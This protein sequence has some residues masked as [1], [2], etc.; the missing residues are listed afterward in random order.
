MFGLDAL[1]LC[2]VVEHVSGIHL[3]Y[4][5]LGFDAGTAEKM[6]VKIKN[7]AEPSGGKK[8]A[9]WKRAESSRDPP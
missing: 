3:V 6:V 5:M 2:H 8:G 9:K 4:G 1:L 7:G